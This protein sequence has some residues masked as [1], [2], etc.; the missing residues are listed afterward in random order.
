MT[1]INKVALVDVTKVIKAYTIRV[2]AIF[3]FSWHAMPV[4]AKNSTIQ[5]YL[6]EYSLCY[7]IDIKLGVN[8]C[9][10]LGR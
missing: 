10:I 3:V 8:W 7:A 9:C 1:F 4:N 6:R 2:R 5:N